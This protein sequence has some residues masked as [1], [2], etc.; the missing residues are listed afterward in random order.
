[1]GT[2]QTRSWW[3]DYR[4]LPG[5]SLERPIRILGR[6][7]GVCAIPAYDGFVALGSTL[8]ATNYTN[9]KSVWI[10]RNCPTGISGNTCQE[11]GDWCSLHNYGIAVDIDPFGYGNPH[12]NRPFGDRWNFSNC[13]ITRA[14][15]EAVENIKNIYGEQMFRWLGWLIGDT[16]HFEYIVPPTRTQVD[17]NTV[18]GG[19]EMPL[20]PIRY[21][22]ETEDTRLLQGYLNEAYGSGLKEDSIYGP[23]TQSAILNSPMLSY[24]GEDEAVPGGSV[25][26]GK[27]VNARMWRGLNRD[28]VRKVAGTSG[29]T[30]TQAEQLFQAKGTIPGHGHRYA[31]EDH[32]HDEYSKPGHGHDATVVEE[33]KVRLT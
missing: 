26:A 33:T 28:W 6:D 21:G 18:P 27:E 19:V 4:C 13:K 30:R 20:L 23:A 22:D 17:W 5:T 12:F 2:R 9:V 8:I 11:D 15:V 16:M 32:D 29:L 14:Q 1:M 31:P 3:S 10:P 7:A 24:T 25:A